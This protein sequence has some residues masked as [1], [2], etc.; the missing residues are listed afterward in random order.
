MLLLLPQCSSKQDPHDEIKELN[1][2][3]YK[4]HS[5][6]ITVIINSNYHVMKS[7]GP[8]LLTRFNFNPSMDK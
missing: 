1:Q 5:P 7:S 8:F 6:K 3:Q 4:N 2:K